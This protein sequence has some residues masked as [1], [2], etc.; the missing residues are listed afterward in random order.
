[1]ARDLRR[2]GMPYVV[3]PHGGLMSQVLERSRLKK[4]AY[5]ALVERAR[6][7]RAS[8]IAYVTPAGEA[9]IRSFVPDFDGPVRWVS[10]PVDVDGLGAVGWRPWGPRPALTFLG[11]FD[12]YHKGIDRLA[13][14]ARRVPEADFQ[15]FGVEDPKTLRQLDVIRR[16]APPNLHI[17]SPIFGAEKLDAL[18][19][20][21]MY[22]Q[23]SRW[24]A[25]SISIL[26][27][28]AMGVPCVI[29]ESM[30]MAAMFREHDLGLVVSTNSDLAALQIRA[31]LANRERLMQWSE[32]SRAYARVHAA[33]AAVARSIMQVYE[34]AVAHYYSE[35][36]M[37]LAP[38]VESNGY[39]G[40]ALAHF[41]DQGEQEDRDTEELADLFERSQRRVE[42]VVDSIPAGDD[43]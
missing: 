28:L 14:I 5:S 4:L 3:T 24:E 42:K 26:E 2:W 38:A 9:D 31:A 18:S 7:R 21:T 6:I 36:V 34:E 12:V 29:S 30:S 39:H 40:Q 1:L 32:T 13:E 23:V 19:R 37:R 20:S 10:N 25:L 22:I 8:A 11:R 27:A 16:Y 33:P 41:T 35:R 15:L 17:Y 43:A